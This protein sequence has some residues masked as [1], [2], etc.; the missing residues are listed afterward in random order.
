MEFGVFAR[1]HFRWSDCLAPV[2]LYLHEVIERNKLRAQSMAHQRAL[3]G[4]VRPALISPTHRTSV[5]TR[6]EQ[7][8]RNESYAHSLEERST[9][10]Q[11]SAGAPYS[12]RVSHSF[13]ERSRRALT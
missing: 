11:R 6:Q 8:T 9:A 13:G 5:T 10:R 3:E 12:L 2:A 4:A 1:G 7:S